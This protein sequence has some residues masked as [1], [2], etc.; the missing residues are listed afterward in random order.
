MWLNFSKEILETVSPNA[1]GTSLTKTAGAI[2]SAKL[3]TDER[4]QEVY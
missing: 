2:Q 3:Q 4:L 1:K